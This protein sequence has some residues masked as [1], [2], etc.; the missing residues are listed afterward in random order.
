MLGRE[1]LARLDDAGLAICGFQPL[2][3]RHDQPQG[4]EHG[5]DAAEELAAHQRGDHAGLEV[6]GECKVVADQERG[7][8]AVGDGEHL[9][10]GRHDPDD[11]EQGQHVGG[12]GEE[13]AHALGRDADLAA[14]TG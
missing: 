2:G 3:L 12:G 8:H 5:E 10:L 9:V 11:A 4:E 14:E 6:R 1:V 7:A 13:A